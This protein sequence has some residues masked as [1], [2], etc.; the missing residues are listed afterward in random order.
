MKPYRSRAEW[1]KLNK[2]KMLLHQR[3]VSAF[4]TNI[5]P[6]VPEED[7]EEVLYEDEKEHEVEEPSEEQEKS[8]IFFQVVV[9]EEVQPVLETP[10]ESRKK[11]KQKIRTDE[12]SS[13][14]CNST[15]RFLC[16]FPSWEQRM[17]PRGPPGPQGPP[18]TSTVIAYG[19]VGLTSTTVVYRDV[20]FKFYYSCFSIRLYF[21]G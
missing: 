2:K 12:Q 16:N 8:P 7:P 5:L 9:P 19:T 10:V 15:Y 14:A 6:K 1:K 20:Y 3:L 4:H 11:R 18:G 13:T 21:R 17:G